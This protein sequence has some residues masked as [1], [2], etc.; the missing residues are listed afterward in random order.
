LALRTEGTVDTLALN[1]SLSTLGTVAADM[2]R[3]AA[4]ASAGQQHRSL[5]GKPAEAAHDSQQRRPK[6]GLYFDDPFGSW[7]DNNLSL[8]SAQASRSVELGTPRKDSA[9]VASTPRVGDSGYGGDHQPPDAS[10]RTLQEQQQASPCDSDGL[11]ANSGDDASPEPVASGTTAGPPGEP[12]GNS[13]A[14][15]SQ[16]GRKGKR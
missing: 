5:A 1:C 6:A 7:G 15:E 9:A 13:L 12:S 8:L 11:T 10:G 3:R 14:P 2:P 16:R 4:A